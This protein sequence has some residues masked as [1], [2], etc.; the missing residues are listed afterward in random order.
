MLARGRNDSL[1]TAIVGEPY[2]EGAKR[3]RFLLV[4]RYFSTWNLCNLDITGDLYS[5]CVRLQKIRSSWDGRDFTQCY[6]YKFSPAR[7]RDNSALDY[8]SLLAGLE[9][10][11]PPVE[12]VNIHQAQ[13][14]PSLAV[15]LKNS[16]LRNSAVISILEHVPSTSPGLY[17][18]KLPVL[19]TSKNRHCV[20]ALL[21][22]VSSETPV[23]I[24]SCCTSQHQQN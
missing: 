15:L 22:L 5:P 10:T 16:Q 20:G 24:H 14:S 11:V 21:K 23:W 3:A 17:C 4:M 18:F 12:E 6:S 2:K 9:L 13:R 19:Y 1:M 8:P 7:C